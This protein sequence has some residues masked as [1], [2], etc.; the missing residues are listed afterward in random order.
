MAYLIEPKWNG[1]LDRLETRFDARIPPRKR[2]NWFATLQQHYGEG[3][4]RYHD[5]N[6]INHLIRQLH[7][8]GLPIAR[9]PLAIEAAIWFHD[10]VMTPGS[11]FNE[12]RSR[13][14]FDTFSREVGLQGEFMEIVGDLILI[15][16]LK[17]VP[18]TDDQ[19]VMVD[20]DL[21][22]LGGSWDHFMEMNRQIREEYVD[23]GFVTAQAYDQGRPEFIRTLMQRV[24]IYQ[25]STFRDLYEAPARQNMSRYLLACQQ[26]T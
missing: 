15:T 5:A 22:A 23:G 2:G 20:I 12:T 1:L 3:W 21:T 17:N 25:T 18:W 16:D 26:E 11:E 10:A 24:R 8:N 9:D 4:R 6:H 7:D 14:L 19:K 13:D